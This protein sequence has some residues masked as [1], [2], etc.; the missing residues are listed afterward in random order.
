M[1][2]SDA[3]FAETWG[4]VREGYRVGKARQRVSRVEVVIYHDQIGIFVQGDA[5]RC[6]RT[7]DWQDSEAFSRLKHQW[8]DVVCMGMRRFA[9]R[10][11][12]L[13]KVRNTR[14]RRIV[15][16]YHLTLYCRI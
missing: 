14:G 8:Q 6:E 10:G 13:V 5:Q 7:P 9:S 1:C 3:C 16:R 4:H 15:Q 12:E 11:Y 2:S